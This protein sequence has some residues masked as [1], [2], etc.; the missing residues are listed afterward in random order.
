MTEK[1]KYVLEHYEISSDGKVYSPYTKKFLKFRTDKDG[2]FDV[3]LIYNDEGK[4]QPFRV[5]RLVALK[6][7]PEVEGCSIVNHKDLNKQ[8]NVVDNLEWCTVAYNTQHGFDNSAYKNIQNVKVTEL[9]GTIRIFPSIAH[10]ARFY[11]YKNATTIEHT[12]KGTRNASNP[13]KKGKC[14]GFLFE[15]TKESVTTIER[16]SD[17]VVVENLVEYSS[18]E[19]LEGE[20]RGKE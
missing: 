16:R 17:T 14:K 1:E 12:L 7:L 19:I 9:D 10:A 8:N 3:A 11:G 2:Y 13:P 4:R 6:Y 18:S 20:A 5:H 15:F